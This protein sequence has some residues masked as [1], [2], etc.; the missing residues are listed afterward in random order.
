MG[1]SSE[2]RENALPGIIQRAL[3]KKGLGTESQLEAGLSL[4]L[5]SKAEIRKTMQA[6]P[7]QLAYLKVE[8]DS[9]KT[10][11]QRKIGELEGKIEMDA[12]ELLRLENERDIEQAR[13]EAEALELNNQLQRLTD[14]LNECDISNTE[15]I[16]KNE[17]IE[18]ELVELEE[19]RSSLEMELDQAKITMKE[20]DFV[21]LEGCQTE[22]VHVTSNLQ[23]EL[24]IVKKSKTSRNECGIDEQCQGFQNG[25]GNPCGFKSAYRTELDIALQ[26]NLDLQ[27]EHDQLTVIVE[28]QK[29]TMEGRIRQLEESNQKHQE[30]NME[31]M[32]NSKVLINEVLNEGET[33][34]KELSKFKFKLDRQIQITALRNHQIYHN[35]EKILWLEDKE[36]GHFSA[37]HGFSH[38]LRKHHA[39]NLSAMPEI[40]SLRA[41][42][43]NGDLLNA[44]L[45][46]KISLLQQAL[47]AKNKCWQVELDKA[48][49]RIKVLEADAKDVKRK[50]E[51]LQNDFNNLDKTSKQLATKLDEDSGA[52]AILTDEVKFLNRK[53]TA[54]KAALP[55]Q[56]T[57]LSFQ[58]LG[59]IP[60]SKLSMPRQIQT[61]LQEY[62]VGSL[63]G[64][65]DTSNNWPYVLKQWKDLSKS[66]QE[67]M[68]NET[69]VSLAARDLN[70]VATIEAWGNFSSR[71]KPGIV[72]KREIGGTRDE[73][74][75]ANGPFSIRVACFYAAQL[76]FALFGI[77]SVGIVHRDVKLVNILL[78]AKGNIKLADFGIAGFVGETLLINR[79]MP[80]ISSPEVISISSP[81][82]ISGQYDHGPAD[83]WWSLGI[84]TYKMLTGKYPYIL[85]VFKNSKDTV[86]FLSNPS[87]ITF[88]PGFDSDAEKFIEQ[89]ETGCHPIPAFFKKWLSKKQSVST[90]HNLNKLTKK[91]LLKIIDH[92]NVKLAK[93]EEDLNTANNVIRDQ[94]QDVE[95]CKMEMKKIMEKTD[96]S[97]NTNFNLATRI[98]ELREALEKKEQ[99]NKDLNSWKVES[100]RTMYL[101]QLDLNEVKNK[102]EASEKEN[103]KL[104]GQVELLKEDR[105]NF[106]YRQTDL[107]REQIAILKSKISRLKD[108]VQSE[109]NDATFWKRQ[110]KHLE[111]E[112]LWRKK[113][114]DS[115]VNNMNYLRNSNEKLE[116]TNKILEKTVNTMADDFGI[117]RRREQ[118][119]VSLFQTVFEKVAALRD[120]SL[121]L[122]SESQD[123]ITLASSSICHLNLTNNLD[124]KN[125][126]E[127]VT[128]PQF[129]ALDKLRQKHPIEL[130]GDI[131]GLTILIY[132]SL[133]SIS[134]LKSIGCHDNDLLI[135]AMKK[136]VNTTFVTFPNVISKD[137]QDLMKDWRVGTP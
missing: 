89:H 132:E 30:A 91:A 44:D 70:F 123:N 102:L 55:L 26:A 88:P 100:S 33:V 31:L 43:Q 52:N 49:D 62:D 110:L 87:K 125:N 101:C 75:K 90:D 14:S 118:G 130:I 83:D 64:H 40:N 134:S 39:Q 109:R 1:S 104:K 79:F 65:G 76:V 114:F 84:C 18:K 63:L 48:N 38:Q 35:N 61:N 96:Q 20:A 78:D 73:K 12:I 113:Q 6:T 106:R 54:L 120:S 124:I 16:S 137:A 41:R 67:C 115:V 22:L 95:S 131:C 5:M 119:R 28:E 72:Y 92:Q 58:Q 135:N 71:Q 117:L 99:E 53:V 97:N 82:V 24:G 45:Q 128:A 122:T 74:L 37:F 60:T 29:M 85:S 103:R 133:T 17:R 15:L 27:V 136:V 13:L 111:E 66:S 51:K 47:K 8:M 2:R 23:Q 105:A 36:S 121:D 7:A 126:D 10:S 21:E 25:S 46:N 93:A 112:L 80:G 77:H 19:I 94:Q 116:K 129:K 50:H 108:K 9:M 81:E 127:V 68:R 86:A 34:N 69:I 59:Q 98:V 3:T 107:V 11:L 42:V 57:P 56:C 32:N 4:N